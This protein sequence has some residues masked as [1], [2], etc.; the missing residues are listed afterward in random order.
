[1]I[2][3]NTGR[4]YSEHGQRIVA[5]MLRGFVVFY[6]IDRGIFGI[7]DTELT[8]WDIM[9]AYDAGNYEACRPNEITYQDYEWFVSR[10]KDFVETGTYV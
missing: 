8:Q 4:Q 1:M 5:G 7:V 9:L 3:W 2:K 10:A 6:D